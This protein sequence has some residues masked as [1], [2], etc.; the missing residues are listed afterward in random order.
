MTEPSAK[1]DTSS[2]VAVSGDGKTEAGMGTDA[3]DTTGNGRLDLIVTHLDFEL[4]RLYRNLGDGTFDDATFPAKLGY[5]T[6]HL[7]GFGTRFMDYDND[8]ARDLFIAN[9]HIL[10]NIELVHAGTHYAEPKLMFRNNGTW[11]I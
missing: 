6:F 9:G 10:D 8:G 4:A 1:S 2:G 7:S 11:R 3:A 5:A